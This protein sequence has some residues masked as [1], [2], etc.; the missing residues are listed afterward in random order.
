MPKNAPSEFSPLASY[1]ISSGLNQ[2]HSDRPRSNASDQ[3]W[4]EHERMAN[5]GHLAILRQG[6]I[7]WNEWRDRNPAVIADL[8]GADL[9]GVD[10]S[11]AN[12]RGA[13]L[14]GAEL[15]EANLSKANLSGAN[16][17]GAQLN[18]AN[19]GE[20]NLTRATLFAAKLGGA[21]LAPPNIDRAHFAGTL[22]AEFTGANLSGANLN[23]ATLAAADLTGVNLSMANLSEAQILLTVFANVDL[24]TTKGLNECNHIG[25]STVDFQ[26]LHRSQNLPISFLRGCGLPDDLIEYLPSLHREAIQFYS[27]FISYSAK[28]QMFAE[29]LHADLQDKGV[30]CWFAP[31]DL[32]IGAK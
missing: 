9:S 18:G 17:S 5:D 15:S 2:P 10:L 24:T 7:V 22:K 27:C 23:G 26:T 4:V 1:R 11:N 29:R 20:A 13:F 32:P 14:F 30:R 28:D 19:L 12:L 31:H 25:P 8:E 6:V 16:L 21:K 3:N